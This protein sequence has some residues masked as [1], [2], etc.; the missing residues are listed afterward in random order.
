MK[1][2]NTF[3]L[4]LVLLLS[5]WPTVTAGSP[6]DGARC[7]PGSKAHPGVTIADVLGLWPTPTANPDNKSPEAHLAMKRRMGERDGTNANRTAIL[8]ADATWTATGIDPQKSQLTQV[9]LFLVEEICFVP[10]TEVVTSSGLRP[11]SSVNSDSA[12][13]DWKCQGNPN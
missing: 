12:V 10:G 4:A 3:V 2:F 5:L 8:D 6:T 11:K 7:N 1:R 9:H 13:V